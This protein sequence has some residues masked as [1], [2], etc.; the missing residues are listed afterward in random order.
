MTKLV[1]LLFFGFNS[2]VTDLGTFNADDFQQLQSVVTQYAKAADNQSIA[3]FK[4][5]V[6][7]QFRVVVNDPQKEAI[8]VIDK[9]T[10]AKLLEAKRIGGA[11]RELVIKSIS[12]NGVNASVTASLFKEV[13]KAEFQTV[14]SFVKHK[15]AWILIE[16]MAYVKV[17][18]Q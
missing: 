13:P 6:H 8:T 4:K 16:E 1:F 17:A 7:D 3:D 2:S 9:A 15:G 11:P 18:K 14:Y 12:I 10:Y 5:L